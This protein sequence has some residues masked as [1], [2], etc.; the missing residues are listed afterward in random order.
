MT[1]NDALTTTATQVETI[2]A[3]HSVTYTTT[4]N[5]DKEEEGDYRITVGDVTAYLTASDAGE[6]WATTD[7]DVGTR[8]YNHWGSGHPGVLVTEGRVVTY[9]LSADI[10]PDLF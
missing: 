7:G 1:T 3:D 5:R 6:V 10:Y 2:L 8:V 9:C 4:D